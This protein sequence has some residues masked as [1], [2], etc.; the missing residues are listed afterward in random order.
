[1]RG[2]GRAARA[3]RRAG[4]AAAIVA[5]LPVLAACQRGHGNARMDALRQD[6][7]LRCSVSG[8]TPWQASDIAGTDHGI[9]F[10]GTL[11]T[12]VSRVY[13][14]DAARA[15]EVLDAF[16]ACA[17]DAGW[18]ASRTPYRS[19]DT[20]WVTGTKAFPGGWTGY[21][22]VSAGTRVWHDQPAVLVQLTT[23]AG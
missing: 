13:H 17:R 7:L 6:P 20:A 11:P 9:G 23:E 15:D 5:A 21:L 18:R 16:L 3:L 10:G 22:R 1:M 14:L 4:A 2:P 8:A 12:T 19:R